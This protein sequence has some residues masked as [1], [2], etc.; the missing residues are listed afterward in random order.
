MSP[1]CSGLSRRVLMFHLHLQI[2]ISSHQ[3]SVI[4]CTEAQSMK[5][6]TS[7]SPA[8]NI[9]L[10]FLVICEESI[11]DP[12]LLCEVSRKCEHF[13]LLRTEG[14]PLILPVLVQVHRYCVIL[15]FKRSVTVYIFFSKWQFPNKIMRN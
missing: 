5:S 4:S 11:W 15:K 9:A 10:P 13:V 2:D 6:R 3:T 7:L 12:D 1:S 8:G 14:K